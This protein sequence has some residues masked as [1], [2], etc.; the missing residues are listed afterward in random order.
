MVHYK[1]SL[2]QWLLFSTMIM[3]WGLDVLT[4][5][6]VHLLESSHLTVRGVLNSWFSDPAQGLLLPSASGSG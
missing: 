6:W 5:M 2:G 1:Y 4:P 3:L